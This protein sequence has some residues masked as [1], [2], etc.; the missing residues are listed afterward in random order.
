MIAE[1]AQKHAEAR[2]VI[3]EDEAL[4]LLS[5]AG[6]GH[7]PLAGRNALRLL[8][9]NAVESA[10]Y[11]AVSPLP[12]KLSPAGLPTQQTDITKAGARKSPSEGVLGRK[13]LGKLLEELR[14]AESE[15]HVDELFS[16]LWRDAGVGW[17][18]LVG[19]V[20]DHC[21]VEGTAHEL[22]RRIRAAAETLSAGPGSESS[23][24]TVSQDNN[25]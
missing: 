14:L 10:V 16:Q 2:A 4:R 13:Q 5:Q 9:E 22:T 25:M 17:E 23:F 8:F 15:G 11:P 18:A 12:S 19:L 21:A 1:Q 3:A 20:E 7:L 24:Q 6:K